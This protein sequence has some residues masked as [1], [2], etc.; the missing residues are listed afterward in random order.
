MTKDL[1]AGQGKNL[2]LDG[3]WYFLFTCTATVTRNCDIATSN[4]DSPKSKSYHVAVNL[5][6]APCASTFQS[7]L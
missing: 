7:G 5:S 2:A 3:W 6:A 1:V 4:F